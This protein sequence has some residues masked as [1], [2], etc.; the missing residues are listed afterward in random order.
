MAKPSLWQRIKAKFKKKKPLFTEVKVKSHETLK[1]ARIQI[2]QQIMKARITVKRLRNRD[3][4]KIP[5]FLLTFDEIEGMLR[6]MPLSLP[7]RK[8]EKENQP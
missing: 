1:Q 8:D 3:K 5:I 2:A 4:R 7:S 6:D